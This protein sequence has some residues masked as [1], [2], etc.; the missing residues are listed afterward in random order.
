MLQRCTLLLI[1]LSVL[2][3]AISA[4]GAT[5]TPLPTPTPAPTWTLQPTHMPYLTYTPSPLSLLPCLLMLHQFQHQLQHLSHHQP[6][7][8]SQLSTH[9][10]KKPI[11]WRT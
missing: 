10:L 8:L 2:A 5:P 11:I 6:Q 4:C 9:E 7:H 3:L 1:A